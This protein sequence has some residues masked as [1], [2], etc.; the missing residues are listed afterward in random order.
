MSGAAPP[1]FTG[2]DTR[3]A[4][5]FLGSLVARGGLPPRASAVRTRRIR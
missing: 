2:T 4:F 5:W 3:Q 1:S